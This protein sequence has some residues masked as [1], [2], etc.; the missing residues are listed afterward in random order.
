LHFALCILHYPL[1][2][3]HYPLPIF[4]SA[5][6]SPVAI[7]IF[8]K[9]GKLWKSVSVGRTLWVFLTEKEEKITGKM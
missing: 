8:R 1:S 6:S 2:I 3:I 5:F 7:V 4:H 9:W